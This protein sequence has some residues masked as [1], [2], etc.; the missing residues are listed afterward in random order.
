MKKML[1]VLLTLSLVFCAVALAED[2]YDENDQTATT[3]LTTTITDPTKPVPT[4]TIVIP[5]SLA[6][7]PNATQTTLTVQ[8]QEVENTESIQVTADATGSMTNGSDGTIDF[9]ISSNELSFSNFTSLPS[10][11]TMSIN[12]TEEE[13][14]QAPAGDYTGTVNF[15]I[16]ATAAE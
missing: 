13:W 11:K 12:I 5:S 14:N 6:I 8:V 9:T 3:T 7:T 2:T 16:S 4:Y 1:C 15:T 10:S